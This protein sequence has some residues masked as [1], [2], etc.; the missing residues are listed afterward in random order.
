MMPVGTTED[1]RRA[2]L[3][4][5]LGL[6]YRNGPASRASLG[7]I[8]GRNRSTIARLVT[9]L[10]ELRLADER[11]P[12]LE[13]RRVG[14]PSP[15]VSLRPEATAIAINPEIDVLTIGLVGL[16]G[17][18]RR[19]VRHEY[20]RIPTAAEVTSISAA[21]IAGMQV[22]LEGLLVVGIGVAVPG[23]V[24]T[25]T[26]VVR[27]AP[28]LAWTDEPMA[29][30]LSKAT[31]YRVSVANDAALG[32]LAEHDFGAGRCCEHLIYLN[33]GASGIGGGVISSGR[34]LGGTSGHAGEFGHIR[35]SSSSVE[36]SAGI[37][38]TLEAEVSRFALQEALG[39][40]RVEP[41]TFNKLL[42]ANRTKEVTS[43][44]H[45]QLEHLGS[46]VATAI[47]LFDPQ[48]IALGGFLAALQAYDQQFLAE[49][50]ASSALAP[51]L[52]D[53]RITA[54]ELGEDLLM[55]GAARL[56]FAPLLAD[57][58]SISR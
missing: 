9:D 10:V 33:G 48:V 27:N 36:D 23:Q 16:D 34:L 39:L 21:V 20:D 24:Q 18:V 46:A 6:L 1:V 50:V 45:R 5:I 55:I 49:Q 52:E 31:G 37:V 40:S 41:G 12:E 4:A 38:G 3:A 44:V 22:E 58:A 57:P 56:A 7:R 51:S 8:T 42:L 53:V 14:R 54:T 29:E 32:A 13:E 25:A 19:V 17:T 35:V 2:N 11:E 26:G 15:V 47:N 28:H 43:V 30:Q